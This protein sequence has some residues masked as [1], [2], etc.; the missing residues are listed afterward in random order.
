[1]M[2]FE[3]A[4]LEQ[5]EGWRTVLEAYRDR[6]LQLKESQADFDGWVPRITGIDS[7]EDEILSQIHGK[8]IAL[9]LLNMQLG[10]R[11][12]GVRYQLTRLGRGMLEGP[13]LSVHSGDEDA[14]EA[15]KEVA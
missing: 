13:I 15:D 9:G 14:A 2:E 7:F 6:Q 1:M 3:L 8:L 11:T 4:M 12:Q 5:N 10:S